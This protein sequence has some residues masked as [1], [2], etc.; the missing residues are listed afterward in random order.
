MPTQRRFKPET[1][2]LLTK[3]FVPILREDLIRRQRLIDALQSNL[4][5]EAIF[6]RRLTLISASAGFGKTTLLSE[7]VQ[8]IDT[9]VAWLSLDRG[10]NNLS[11]FLT[12]F[13]AALQTI[14]PDLGI[15]P[16]AMLHSDAPPPSEIV[17]TALINE[18]AQDS[19]PYLIIIDDY[20]VIVER[21]IHEAISFLLNHAPPNLHLV[22]SSRSDPPINMSRLRGRDE[23]KELR[24]ADL[25]F[26]ADETAAFL[27]Q[28]M[29][30]ALSPEDVH[31]LEKRIEGW[32]VGLQLAAL[33]IQSP[34][35][36]Q[37]RASEH[38]NGLSAF[39]ANQRYILDYFTDEVL[40]QQPQEIQDFLLQTAILDQ[41]TGS[42]CNHLTDREDGQMTLLDLEKANLFITPLDHDQRWYRYHHLFADLLRKH[43]IRT[44]PSSMPGLHRLA[45]E[46][47]ENNGMISEAL[48]H[49]IALGDTVRAANLVEENALAM[50][51]H[52]ELITLASWLDELPDQVVRSRPLLCV[53]RAWPMAYAGQVQAI[54]SL[55]QDATNSF[56]RLDEDV[57]DS[58]SGQRIQGHIA[59]IQAQILGIQGELGRST[60]MA[61]EALTRLPVEDHLARGWAQFHLGFML[62]MLGE[63]HTA[64]QAFDE[65]IRVN[66]ASGRSHV[67]V[68]ALCEKAALRIHLGQLHRAEALCR[69]A[70]A[71]A[72]IYREERGMNLPAAGHAF[73]RLSAVL[74][75]WNQLDEAIRA[76]EKGLALC[77]QWGQADG[78][79]EGYLHL[80][81]VLH[82][83]GNEQGA[84]NATQ[85]AT[86]VA[87][88]VSP[89]FAAYA[90]S[91]QARFHLM[92]G[93]N[94]AT[95]RWVQS[96]GLS[97]DD[98][99]AFQFV[100]NYLVLAR[101]LLAKGREKKSGVSD[102]A[103]NL[104]E[105]ILNMAEALGANSCLI[106]ALILHAMAFQTRGDT[107]QALAAIERALHLAHS[108][109]FTRIFISEGGAM[110]QLLTRAIA[111]GIEPEYADRLLEALQKAK[112]EPQPTALQSGPSDGA[113]SAPQGEELTDREHQI[114]RLISAG[115]S[116]RE[117]AE[118]LYLSINTIKTH[119]KNLYIK[120]DVS[121][122]TQAVHRAKKW[123]IL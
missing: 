44:R 88:D 24:T 1:S 68:L 82:D 37:T 123:G 69:E 119:T 112:P 34:F 58:P 120:L 78:M 41:L 83:S 47:Y 59:A 60:A 122:R 116:N 100:F 42:L 3:I 57:Q 118:E 45:S 121:S 13:I 72:E 43:L 54:E 51:D 66:Q 86:R 105:R 2:P 11:R 113:P 38:T 23:L 25:R 32:V 96:A 17:L 29:G 110:E 5:Q 103:L 91:R 40:L 18:I 98:E 31:A 84:R 27:H 108:E 14:R 85:M 22:I 33:S 94:K 79:L 87:S 39:A 99:V 74:R 55:L 63:F 93:N 90:A 61:R 50:L 102:E 89:W 77:K 7:W 92:Q 48:R 28:V 56:A 62:R 97:A 15:E 26:T 21:T 75:E 95:A 115:L 117:I 36:P 64:D 9:S 71:L 111:E 52:G 80:A 109:G 104:I 101:L 6:N 35:P 73:L 46:W 76:A 30:L 19:K 49:L 107:E 53:T 4:R 16:M 8:S 114:L 81:G 12:Y 20:H 67:V 70:I 10:D 65:A 106:E